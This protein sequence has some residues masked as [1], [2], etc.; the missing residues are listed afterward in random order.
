MV[1]QMGKPFLDTTKTL[2]LDPIGMRSSGFQ[3]YGSR[4][5]NKVAM[6]VDDQEKPIPGGPHTYPELAGA[7]L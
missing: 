6:P 1:D 3:P 2:V 5:P 4:N 7:G